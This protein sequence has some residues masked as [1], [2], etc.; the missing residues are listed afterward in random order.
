MKASFFQFIIIAIII[1]LIKTQTYEQVSCKT[2]IDPPSKY[3]C[4][5]QSKENN[6]CCYIGYRDHA[7]QVSR[8]FEL[9]YQSA[10]QL[11]QELTDQSNQLNQNIGSIQATCGKVFEQCPTIEKPAQQQDCNGLQIEIPYKCCFIIRPNGERSCYPVNQYQIG[12]FA[13][14]YQTKHVLSE[15]PI[16]LCQGKYTKIT[17]TIIGILLIFLL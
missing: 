2:I 10:D 16:V 17:F 15:R 9:Q 6:L 5:F 4:L 11:I 12:S 3:D 14:E 1:A 13:R 8:C 7:N